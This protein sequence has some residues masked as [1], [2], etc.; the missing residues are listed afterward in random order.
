MTECSVADCTAAAAVGR[1]GFCH[2]H[3]KRQYRYG[4]PNTCLRRTAG[5][6]ELTTSGYIYHNSEGKQ[7]YEHVII[8]E[9]ALGKKLPIGAVVHHID[10]NPANNQ[11]N[12]LVVC[13]NHQY[14]KLLHT[15]AQW[16]DYLNYPSDEGID[17]PNHDYR[18]RWIAR[19]KVN[20]K[21]LHIGSFRSRAEAIDARCT[22]IKLLLG[23]SSFKGQS[24]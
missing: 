5:E 18:T 16:I 19:I 11:A 3:Y 21:K 20:K 13:P 23:G 22:V 6:G 8:V 15:R 24:L 2:K 17:A 14:H 9:K 10:G 12:N 1:R 7:G 4:D